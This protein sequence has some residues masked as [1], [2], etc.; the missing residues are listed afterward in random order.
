VIGDIQKQVSTAPSSSDPTVGTLYDDPQ[1]QG[2]L[3]TMRSQMYSTEN[4][5]SPSSIQSML[6]IGV[7]TGQTTGT[8]AVSRSAINGNLQLNST[9][10]ASAL[11]S[12]P[13]GFQQMMVGF[14]AT[15]ST[16]VG[17][18]SDPGGSI[19]ARIQGDDQQ[20]SSLSNRISAMQSTLADKQAQL[21][22]QFAQLEAALSS[23]QS[24]ASWLTS[25]IAAL[26]GA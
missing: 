13:T 8:G 6:D 26:P 10:L 11:Q 7:S 20:N 12:D 23:N 25:Q 24:Q 1:L 16:M 5:G 19:D 17:S 14:A 21:V 15:F 22:Q 4:A 9:T 2:L 3:A 18:Q